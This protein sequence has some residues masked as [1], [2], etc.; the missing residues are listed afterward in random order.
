[1]LVTVLGLSLIAAVSWLVVVAQRAALVRAELAGERGRRERA[2]RLLVVRRGTV[3]RLAEVARAGWV[4]D[5][6]TVRGTVPIKRPG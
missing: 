3:A 5:A 2:E 1:L 6:I 4:G